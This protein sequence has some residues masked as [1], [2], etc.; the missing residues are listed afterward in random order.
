MEKTKSLYDYYAQENI[1]FEQLVELDYLEQRILKNSYIYKEFTKSTVELENYL[2]SLCVFKRFLLEVIKLPIDVVK[3]STV[4]KTDSGFH[5][6]RPYTLVLSREQKE[7]FSI[8]DSYYLYLSFSDAA[9]LP[10]FVE[11]I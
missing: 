6:L 3:Y 9:K 7:L 5:I 10:F 8:A 4:V 2:R 11:K 1:E